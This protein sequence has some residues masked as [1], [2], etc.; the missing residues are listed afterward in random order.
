MKLT[1]KSLIVIF[2]VSMILFS[3]C[4]FL[5]ADDV[6]VLPLRGPAGTYR[7]SPANGSATAYLMSFS[8]QKSI[9]FKSASN[10][11]VY[12]SSSSAIGT[13]GYPLYNKSETICMDLASG[14]TIYFYGDGAG[15]DVRAFIIR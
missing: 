1:A 6:G 2:G 5:F 12:I 10:T 7:I 11:D 9:C 8:G 14:T 4:A 13:D 15:A 3:I